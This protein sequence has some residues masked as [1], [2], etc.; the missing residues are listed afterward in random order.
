MSNRTSRATGME[1]QTKNF[2]IMSTTALKGKDYH[3][4]IQLLKDAG[5]VCTGKVQTMYDD[6]SVKYTICEI[7]ERGYQKYEV[8]PLHEY[9][10]GECFAKTNADNNTILEAY[11]ED[12]ESIVLQGATIS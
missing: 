5:F 3:E 10:D 12:D 2:T 11:R 6:F 1:F 7:W 4:I 9:A 8:S